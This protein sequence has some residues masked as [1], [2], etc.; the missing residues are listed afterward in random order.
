MLPKLSVTRQ[1]QGDPG[2]INACRV[3]FDTASSGDSD[4]CHV[5]VGTCVLQRTGVF[6]I[7]PYAAGSPWAVVIR[8]LA[9]A[10]LSHAAYGLFVSSSFFPNLAQRTVPLPEA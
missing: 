3:G 1:D 6:R 10:R 2:A 4:G 7:W 9:V 8:P 5:S